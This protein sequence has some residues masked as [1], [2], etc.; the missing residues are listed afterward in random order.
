MK[1]YNVATTRI[2][3]RKDKEGGILVEG[4]IKVYRDSGKMVEFGKKL[5]KSF[6]GNTFWVFL[7]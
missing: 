5:L 3:L 7:D 6:M 1:N 4:A 2:Y